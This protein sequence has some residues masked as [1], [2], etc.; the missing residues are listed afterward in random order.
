MFD[1]LTRGP[2]PQAAVDVSE[3]ARGAGPFEVM[4]TEAQPWSMRRW[5]GHL[6]RTELRLLI[7]ITLIF[8]FLWGFVTL[9]GEVRE[10]DTYRLDHRLLLAF[11]R[12]GAL[13]TPVGPR[14]LQETARDVTAL[15]GFTVLT[16]VIVVSGL[17]LWLH[18]RRLQAAVLVVAVAVGQAAAEGT[19]HLVGRD[20][21]D[22]VPHLDMVYSSSFPS[23]HSAMSPIVYFTLAGILAAGEPSRAAKALLLG[24]AVLLVL[25]VGTSRVYL[26]V[27]WP[28]DVLAGWAMGTAV[29]LLATLALHRF[30]PHRQRP[31]VPAAEAPVRPGPPA[32]GQASSAS[33]PR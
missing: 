12:P 5:V 30:A 8:G 11:R 14:W 32:A 7:G 22:L 21:P 31:G 9:L 19:K 25:A 13:A 17:L 6:V 4:S 27:H 20:R 33:I 28:T 2:D 15:G 1:D 24:G 23:G 10:G 16:L 29:A 3:P 18:R 26:G